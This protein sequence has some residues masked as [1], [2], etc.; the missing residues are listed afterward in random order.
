MAKRLSFLA[1]LLLAAMAGHA[2]GQELAGCS[3]AAADEPPRT[4]YRC[5]GGLVIEAEAATELRAVAGAGGPQPAVVEVEGNAVLIEAGSGRGAFQILTPH[6]IASV[7]G[8]VYAV[9]VSAGSTAVF[10]VEGLVGV[11]R[12]DGAEGVQLEAG[13]GVDV[14]PGEAL[15][16][17][18]WGQGRVDELLARFGR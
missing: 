2:G 18:E 5:E 8:T 1:A 12:R 15:T 17:R 10:V 16:V 11:S 7:R 13:E 14:V 4:V 6:A 9:E 3:A